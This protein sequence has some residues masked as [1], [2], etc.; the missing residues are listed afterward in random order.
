MTPYQ[1]YG[2]SGTISTFLRESEASW[3][4]SM[5]SHHELCMNEP[6][7]SAQVTAWRSS[8]KVLQEQ[9]SLLLARRQ[10]AGEWMLIFE[11]ELPRERG[12]RPDLVMLA[13]D[14]ILVLEFKEYADVLKAHID[15]VSAYGR[16]RQ[17]YHAGSHRH[18][19]FC[20]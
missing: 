9:L 20:L 4:D 14:R 6:P 7:S 2:W 10:A 15:Q 1:G 5:Q 12:R 19:V 17:H 3:L 8:F 16:D 18:P 11:Y 13:G